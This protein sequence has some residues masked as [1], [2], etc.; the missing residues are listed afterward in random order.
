MDDR[1]DT[2]RGGNQTSPRGEDHTS[3]Q[4]HD[5]RRSY[6]GS[7]S[8]SHADNEDRER[9]HDTR[10]QRKKNTPDDEEEDPFDDA[11]ATGDDRSIDVDSL[12]DAFA[13]EEYQE[14][15]AAR[16]QRSMNNADGAQDDQCHQP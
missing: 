15:R 13:H 8:G 4:F 9:R 1:G 7:T 6:R 3:Q 14:T 16:Q 10:G 2:Y 11:A 12:T 5:T